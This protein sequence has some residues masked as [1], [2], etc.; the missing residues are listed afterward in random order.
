M[1][2]RRWARRRRWLGANE[3]ELD[4]STFTPSRMDPGVSF[5]HGK[6]NEAEREVERRREQ[7]HQL[8]AEASGR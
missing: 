7:A 6:G 5:A 8:D 4:P 3:T 2:R 1:P